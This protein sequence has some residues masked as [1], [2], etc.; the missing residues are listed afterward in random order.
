MISI[1]CPLLIYY[2]KSLDFGNANNALDDPGA[3]VACECGA[4][5]K[6]YVWVYTVKSESM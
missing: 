4:P 5:A 1:S 6:R 2:L 3:E